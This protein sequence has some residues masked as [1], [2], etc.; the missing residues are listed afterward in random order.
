M[1]FMTEPEIDT[2]AAIS[3]ERMT[4]RRDV[5][6]F[7]FLKGTFH[8]LKP[9]N[10][11]IVG[12]IFQGV[13]EFTFTP[14]TL[15]EREQLQREEGSI[16]MHCPF[17]T[18]YLLF[19]DSTEQELRAQGKSLAGATIPDAEKLLALCTTYSANRKE[20]SIDPEFVQAFA[21]NDRNVL[22]YSILFDNPTKP[23]C[24]EINP[25][26][27][28]EV[29][30][31]KGAG[32]GL[33]RGFRSTI[34]QFHLLNE[35]IEGVNPDESKDDMRIDS[36][37]IECS[38]ADNL[39][40][41]ASAELTIVPI[42]NVP[43]WLPFRLYPE[44]KID[45]VVWGD[46]SGVDGVSTGDGTL[47]TYVRGVAGKPTTLRFYYHGKIFDRS[48][49]FITLL[50]SVGWYPGY[51]YN[52]YSTFDLTFHS[53]KSMKLASVGRLVST[54]ESGNVT[55][56][57]WKAEKPIRIAS[58][59]IGLYR[60]QLFHSDSLPDVIVL[61][62][63]LSNAGQAELIGSDVQR[64]L[65]LYQYLYGKLDC[66]T[67]YIAEWPEGHGEAFPGLVHLSVGTFMQE[68]SSGSDELFRTHEVAHQWWG[69]CI[70]YK[71]YHD[72][73]LSEAFAEYSGLTYLQTTLKDNERFF[74]MLRTYR[75][76]VRKVRKTLFGRGT[77]A[78]P[79]WLGYRNGT[80]GFSGDYWIT[81]YK[82]G[83]WV[84]HMLRN[85]MLDL[86]TMKEDRFHAMMRDFATTYR[87][88][89]ASTEDFQK[90]VEKYTGSSMEWFFRQWVM[91]SAIPEYTYSWTS[92]EVAGGKYRLRLRVDTKN[93]PDDFQMYVPI[94]I[95]FG[96]GKIARV[97][98]M[99]SGLHCEPEIPLL[100]LKPQDIV[101]NDLESVLCTVDEGDWK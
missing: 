9:V 95:D 79:I 83:A 62:G 59:N 57:H 55:T 28:E 49:D 30:F 87:D 73:W 77:T 85:M 15:V 67:L 19:A 6:R 26:E 70:N 54:S 13:G 12:A 39:T 2:G 22:F 25:Y 90:M 27:E 61:R 10:G 40:I 99:V 8:F 74:K 17:T 29:R 94:R 75:D 91:G 41:R 47:W 45:S 71:S 34:N 44:L 64:S 48:G 42:K 63:P 24:F 20:N 60:E 82:K 31:M 86:T 50:E 58:F 4:L 66:D 37:K 46:G 5:G 96:D 68:S 100:P 16:S 36:Y 14:P 98:V 56:T 53:P 80:E 52:N 92:E 72:Q 35:Y 101:F 93:I 76:E 1:K 3:V 33:D 23:F 7:S 65:H 32:E 69:I 89:K 38:I 51:R 43:M 78:G 11:R 84:L 88:K 18:L 21:N 81:I 97:R